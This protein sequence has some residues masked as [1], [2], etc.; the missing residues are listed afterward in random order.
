MKRIEFIAPVEAMSGNLSGAQNLKYPT[1]SNKA[2]ESPEGSVN[3]ARNYSTRFIGAKRASDGLKYFAVKTKTATHITA[4]SLMAMALL[5]GAGAMYA[6]LVRDKTSE[7]YNNIRAQW[8]ELQNLGNTKTFRAYVMDTFRSTLASKSSNATFAGPRGSITVNNPWVAQ[9]QTVG[10]QVS[11]AIL[12]KF[13]PQL[14]AGNV[15]YFYVNGQ[16]AL[17]Q[18]SGL[19]MDFENLIQ[20]TR[21]NV[22][23]LTYEEIGSAAYVKQGTNFLVNPDGDYV[24]DSDK[25]IQNGKYTLSDIAPTA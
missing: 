9:T 22:L 12:V 4:R 17:A 2:F 6:A 8:I 23:T 10:V 1:D 5:G 14:G 21:L 24:K 7:I 20:D 15:G 16:T 19:G 3:Y 13:F 18:F 25:I 11:Q